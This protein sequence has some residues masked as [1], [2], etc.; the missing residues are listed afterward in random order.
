VLTAFTPSKH[1]YLW[2]QIGVHLSDQHRHPLRNF[3]IDKIRPL[4]ENS[5][6]KCKD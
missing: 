4:G 2:P 1:P 3:G 6:E 5:R